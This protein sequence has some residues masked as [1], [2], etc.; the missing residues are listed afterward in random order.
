MVVPVNLDAS[1]EFIS[2]RRMADNGCMDHTLKAVSV[3]CVKQVQNFVGPRFEVILERI[4]RKP[5]LVKW[6]GGAPEAQLAFLATSFQNFVSVAS[7]LG[8][9]HACDVARTYQEQFLNV[10]STYD[11]YV[12]PIPGGGSTLTAH[13]TVDQALRFAA[14]LRNHPGDSRVRLGL[15]LDSGTVHCQGGNIQGVPPMVAAA[16]A[17]IAPVAKICVTERAAMELGVQALTAS[18]RMTLTEANASA[19]RIAGTKILAA[20]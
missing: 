12:L 16:L 20:W 5:N 18:L 19:N 9:A 4:F 7:E 3:F 14:E 11:A 2:R 17:R 15:G 6:I 8:T 13:R 1:F 10:A